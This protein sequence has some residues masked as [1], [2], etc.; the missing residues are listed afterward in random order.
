MQWEKNFYAALQAAAASL[1]KSVLPPRR[2]RG[3]LFPCGKRTK[4]TLKGASP[5]LRIPCITGVI[6]LRYELRISGLPMVP[7]AV[8]GE[9]PL[10]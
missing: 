2:R 4:S 1:L 7:G 8:R 9:A 3:V 10:L 6:C 5:P